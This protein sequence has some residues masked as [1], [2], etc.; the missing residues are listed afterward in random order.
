MGKA[1]AE[2]FAPARAVFE[3]VD[4]ALSQ[5]A[6]EAHVRGARERSRPHR[7]RPAGADGRLARG[8]ARARGRGRARSCPRRRL[9]R[10][11]FARRI[12]GAGRRRRLSPSPTP[13]VCCACAATPCRRP[14]RSARAPWRRCWAPNSIRPAL[15][16]RRRLWR[17]EAA[18]RR[19]MTMAAGKWSSQAPRRRSI[20]PWSSRRRR[21]S[22]APCCCRC[23]RPSIAR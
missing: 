5:A 19:P 17:P 11:P 4:A 21:G 13:R 8:G 22:S 23:P 1:L 16:R 2:G 9:C 7:Q 18:A 3:E 14:C 12:F 20:A 15:L 10:R 6:L